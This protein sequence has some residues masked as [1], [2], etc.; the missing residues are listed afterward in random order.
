MRTPIHVLACAASLLA[1]SATAQ[2]AQ[3]FLYDANGRLTA[4]TTAR[5]TGDST[6]SYYILDGADNRLGHGAIAVSPPPAGDTFA[7]PYTLVPTQKLTSA[8]GQ[9]T[10]TF[11]PS[12]D[13]VIRNTS[14]A[15]VWN[16]CTGQGRSWFVRVSSD[17]QLTIFDTTG[18]AFW[19]AG[20][21]GNPGAV[22]TL[23][24]SG[25]AILK[26]AGGTTLWTSSTPCA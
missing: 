1:G 9:Y 16:S 17:G 8:N 4:N 23:Q 3:T 5:T 14:G 13:L 12:G 18:T 21:S 2:D 7:F 10:M 15:P 22:L 25:V 19:T 6:R 20:A 11:E 24:N 26:S